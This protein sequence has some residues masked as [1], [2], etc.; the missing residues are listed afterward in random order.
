[1]QAQLTAVLTDGPWNTW[2]HRPGGA[3]LLRADRMGHAERVL[4]EAVARATLRGD[5]GELRTQLDRPYAI[6]PQATPLLPA[7]T[8]R[9]DSAQTASGSRPIESHTEV[10]VPPMTLAN[11]LG[12]FTDEGRAYAIALDGAAE[13]PMPWTN[14][15]ANPQ[16]GTIITASGSAHTWS[17]NSRENRL[18]PF[19]NDPVSDP[20]AEALF[21]RDDE[22]GEYWSPTPGPVTSDLGRRAVPR[23]SHR[24]RD[25]FLPR[26][27]RH[28][29]RAG[30]VR[31]RRRSGEVL[32]A[33][34]PQPQFVGA[35]AQ[36]LRL[37]RVGAGA[38]ARWAALAGRHGARS[39]DT[40]PSSRP[41]RTTRSSPAAWRS[42]VRARRC[43]RLTGDRAIVPRPQRRLVAAGRDGREDPLRRHR[44]RHGSMCRAPC[45]HRARARRTTADRVPARRRRRS[46]PCAAAH[47]TS[48]ARGRGGMALA[49]GARTVG[50]HARRDPGAAR[51]TIRSTR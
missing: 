8:D 42:P 29:P 40:G 16:F 19:A 32:A 47:R 44:G 3:Y 24:R 20:T 13:T 34:D 37:Q 11:G 26:H 15:I 21:I 33:D 2:Q 35:N 25:A 49:R 5:R 10:H 12:G 14:V 39:D 7:A 18:T 31:A 23:S 6:P 4:L 28:R 17:G 51:R 45:P 1:M 30:C 48:S 27:A 46:R 22:T 36:R 9:D 38:A 50:S 41:T 43:I